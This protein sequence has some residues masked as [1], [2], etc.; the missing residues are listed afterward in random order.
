MQLKKVCIGFQYS[1]WHLLDDLINFLHENLLQEDQVVE[2][3]CG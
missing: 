2:K 1:T 3:I